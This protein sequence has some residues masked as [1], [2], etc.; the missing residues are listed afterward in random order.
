MD[1]LKRPCP[2]G[3]RTAVTVCSPFP[4]YVIETT[5]KLPVNPGDGR[6]PRPIP[7]GMATHAFD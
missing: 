3:H 6:F 2:S 7:S 4:M 5:Q 1:A